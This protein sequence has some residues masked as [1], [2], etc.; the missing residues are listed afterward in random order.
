MCLSSC[1]AP[2]VKK[3]APIQPPGAYK[4]CSERRPI[5][6]AVLD[7]GFGHDWQGEEKAHLCN[8]GHKDFTFWGDSTDKFGTNDSVPLDEHGHGTHI[9]GT[10]DKYA[11]LTN[12]SYC[13]VIIKYYE[14]MGNDG[15][16]LE[17]TVKAID[18]AR[19]I[20]ADI[21]NYSGGGIAP[22]DDETA[23]IKRFIDGG[24]TFVAAA[25]NES[26]DLEKKKFYPAQEDSRIIVVGNGKFYA[27]GG[28]EVLMRGE[29]SN[30]GKR[31]DRWEDG[32]GV[33]TYDHAMSG[34]SQAAAIATGKIVAE[35]NKTCK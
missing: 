21:I 16:N 1:L 30:W 7:T 33:I 28:G 19:K 27:I 13:L 24:G 3:L 9:A 31:V 14:P 11:R 34:T 29:K 20:K 26:S 2:A 22:N 5:V 6:I 32:V 4:E 17:N 15:A 8:Y 23:A 25:G 35:K 18:Y 12:N 10:I